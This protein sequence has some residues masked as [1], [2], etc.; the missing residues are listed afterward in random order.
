MAVMH[1]ARLHTCPLAGVCEVD[2][3]VKIEALRSGIRPASWF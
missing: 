2:I 3:Y 1:T